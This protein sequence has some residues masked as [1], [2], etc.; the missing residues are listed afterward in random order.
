[1]RLLT[2][3]VLLCAALGLTA[4]Y[5]VGGREN[6]HALFPDLTISDVLAYKSSFSK[7]GY[8][9]TYVVLRLEHDPATAPPIVVLQESGYATNFAKL[10]AWQQTPVSEGV[11]L[12]E[13]EYCLTGWPEKV[14]GA[15]LE[16]YGAQI[17]KILMQPD[18]W[19][20]VYGSAE[21]KVF[22]V[23]APQE[24]IAIRLRWGD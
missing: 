16:G 11:E 8:G 15:G 6:A 10:G 2:R 12:A 19:F 9:C 4:C 23:Y 3:F 14:E 18:A 21:H 22:M 24:R 17:A 20:S 7:S 13:R 5:N 1:M